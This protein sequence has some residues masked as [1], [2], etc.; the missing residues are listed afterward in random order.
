MIYPTF[1][2]KCNTLNAHHKYKPSLA[3]YILH[4]Y[5]KTLLLHIYLLSPHHYASIATVHACISILTIFIYALKYKL[6]ITHTNT[7]LYF[8]NYQQVQF[9][10]NIIHTYLNIVITFYQILL[11]KNIQLLFKPKSF[12]I[13]RPQNE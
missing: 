2:P 10:T 1:V 4:R 3:Y 9:N 5:T 12:S 6:Y 8:Y 7:Y 13:N 11:I